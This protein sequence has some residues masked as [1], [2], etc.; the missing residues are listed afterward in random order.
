MKGIRILRGYPGIQGTW[1]E[2]AHSSLQQ[3]IWAM[4]T[5]ASGCLGYMG[6]YYTTHLCGDYNKFWA[7]DLP[8]V[9]LRKQTLGGD[10]LPWKL[11]HWIWNLT[12][13]P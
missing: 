3:V 12:G 7:R 10:R 9:K 1:L 4:Q 8:E 11:H 2:L 13:I 6:D 5:R